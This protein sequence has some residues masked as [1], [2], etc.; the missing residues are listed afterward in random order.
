MSDFKLEFTLRQHTPLIHFQ[1]EQA[2]ATL[3]ATEVK[4]RLDAFITEKWKLISLERWQKHEQTIKDEFPVVQGSPSGR[5]K[6]AVQP[7]QL[8]KSSIVA[9]M[10]G[11]YDKNRLES[12]GQ[13]VLDR[14]G[15]FADAKPITDGLRDQAF[16]RGDYSSVRKGLQYDQLTLRFTFFN[17]ALKSLL[18][19]VLPAF[20]SLNNF[21]TRQTKG[22]G[23]FLPADKFT[24]EDF[25][26]ILAIHPGVK[27]VYSKTFS[28]NPEALIQEDYQLLKAG[29]S[30]DNYRKSI[31]WEYFCS[32]GKIRWE[33][34]KIKETIQS[35]KS[36]S[37]VWDKL[38]YEEDTRKNP[39]GKNRIDDCN[40][41]QNQYQFIRALLGL[42]EHYEFMAFG[43]KQVDRSGNPVIYDGKQKEKRNGIKVKISD[44]SGEIAR[45]KSPIL[46]KVFDQKIFLIATEPEPFLIKTKNGNP[47]N[48]EFKLDAE[49]HD[50]DGR[51]ILGLNG[52]LFDLS[53][54]QT[55]SIADFLAFALDPK[56]TRLIKK[57][58]GYERIK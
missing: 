16:E 5:Y 37:N 4:A 43:T 8:S 51:R 33:K 57:I 6:M 39:S 35:T 27:A 30:R 12:L 32:T 53:P 54:P 29:K 7:A 52:K 34:R 38:K 40:P 48:F 24:E 23:C 3:R 20:F 44:T 50:K 14:T 17:R 42:A 19:D 55:F 26:K 45:A 46:F 10:I 36:L 22:F 49:I 18:N 1:H 41:A 15:Y 28:L 58:D 21:G 31:L 13:S 56:D 11:R 47:R 25:K 9:N 2:G